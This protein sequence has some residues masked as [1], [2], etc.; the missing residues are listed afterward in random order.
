M[1]EGFTRSEKHGPPERAG[2]SES[3]RAPVCPAPI[4]GTALHLR[5]FSAT[6]RTVNAPGIRF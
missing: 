2:T 1:K 3:S 6:Y 5:A 4:Y